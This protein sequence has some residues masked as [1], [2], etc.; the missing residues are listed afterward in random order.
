MKSVA[1]Q[2]QIESKAGPRALSEIPLPENE[3]PQILYK[4]HTVLWLQASILL[5][6]YLSLYRDDSDTISNYKY[7]FIV[8]VALFIFISGVH[9]PDSPFLSRPH[10]V[11]WRM[12][13][14]LSFCY[15]IFLT[16]LLFQ[17]I[18]D[19]RTLLTWF[20]NKLGVPLPDKLYA[21]N[22]DIYTPEHPHSYFANLQDCIFD[23]YIL[24]HSIGWWFKM[25]IVR[26]VKLCVFLSVFFEFLEISLQHQLPNFT[27]CWWDSFLLDVVI[28]NGGGIF[29]GWLTCRAFEMREYYWGLGRDSRTQN[30][31]FSALS[32]SAMQLTPYSWSVYKW[33]MFASSKNFITTLWYISF[34]YLVD[35]SNFYLKFTLWIPASHWIL[36]A[37]LLFWAVFAIACTREYYEYVRSG[38]KLRLGTHCWVAHLLLFV[39]WMIVIKNNFGTFTE[40]MPLS[41]LYTWTVI[42]GFLI[43]TALGLFYKDLS[44]K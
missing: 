36:L 32:R 18:D 3:F 20:D 22:C 11:L 1:V 4:A 30:E 16:F 44:H 25:I 43:A 2:T 26:D 6:G 10:P 7:G 12:L 42:L 34:S 8:C 17:N 15:L 21:E 41:I 9:L 39:E 38:F 24:A 28:C 33:E 27:E 35:L 14:G 13:Q 31:R 37:R 19:A 23:V 40:P 5:L 29:L